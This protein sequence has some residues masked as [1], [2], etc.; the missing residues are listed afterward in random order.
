MKI[1]YQQITDKI[2]R[3]P[4]EELAL[5]SGF[6]KRKP[7]KIDGLNFVAGFFMML[8]TGGNSLSDWAKA[9]S[10]L[11]VGLV[12][13]QAV[14]KKLQFRQEAFAYQVLTAALKQSL[15][16]GS[17]IQESKLF[18]FFNKVYLED[19]TCLR[20]PSCLASF[21]PGPHSSKG[22]CASLRI[23]LRLELLNESYEGFYLQPYRDID[24]KHAGV[25]VSIL[26]AGD[27]VIRDLGYWAIK[28]FRAIVE[29]QAYFL[30]RYKYG[31]VCLDA[32]SG[33]RIDLLQVLKKLDRKGI[34]VLD[35]PILLGKEDQL[36]VRLVAIKLTQEVYLTR[37][38]KAE[39]DR[40]QSINHSKEYMELLG[41]A[42][43][44]T[45]VSKQVW[46]FQN[47][48]KAYRFRWRIEI[49][50]KCWK[51]KFY[52]KQLFA[53]KKSIS[54]AR[55]TIT[56]LLFLAFLTAFFVPWAAYFIR[57]VYRYTQK[58][59]SILKFA[60]FVKDRFLDFITT[61]NLA[62]FIPE[63]AYYCTYEKR[64]SRPN[65]LELLY[66]LNLS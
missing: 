20:L 15:N 54:L 61:A 58:W 36:A 50:F 41:W 18:R 10:K 1:N 46:T 32:D 40:C 3:L 47:L 21:F 52:L 45:N 27:L 53:D 44:I 55:V 57:N 5:Q 29:K 11:I 38:R 30:T 34:Q 14:E 63:V 37:R 62:R 33:Q 28:V 8:Q 64:K 2:Q 51:S 56:C 35:I 17:H 49:V 9:I 24:Q 59:V 7:R 66:T 4:I 60:D 19:S 26:Q 22:P 39:K 12:S 65:H 43:F 6:E 31:T 13:K 23:Q 48:I 42:I 16:L 25:I